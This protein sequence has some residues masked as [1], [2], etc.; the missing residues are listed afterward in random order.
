MASV[1]Q[2]IAVSTTPRRSRRGIPPSVAALVFLGPALILLLLFLVYPTISSI[3]MSFIC[4][5]GVQLTQWVGLDNYITVLNTPS[6]TQSIINNVLWLIF[7]TGFVIFFGLVIAV[8]AMRVRYES[9][10]KAVVF[11]PMAIAATALSVIWTFVYQPDP[12]L[13][14]LNAIL[15]IVHIGP[16]SW[17]GDPAFVNAALISVGIL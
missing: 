3:A 12:N 11:L 6:F 2:P 8:V 16:I 13:G 15:G 9:L 14:L 17:L 1:P 7:Y 10:I 5:L 4:F